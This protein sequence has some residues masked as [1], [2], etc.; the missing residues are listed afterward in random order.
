MTLGEIK[1]E[2]LKIMF[3]AYSNDFSVGELEHIAR[4]DNYASYLAD[5]V[6]S[7][8]RCFANIENKGV[9]KS[10]CILLEN[11][12][13][14]EYTVSYDLDSI[15]DFYRLERVIAEKDG[16]YFPS[17]EYVIE[18]NK[19]VL[20]EKGC[21]YK[22]VYKPRIKRITPETSDGENIGVD[23]SIAVLIPYYIKGDVYRDDEPAEAAEARNWYEAAISE[24]SQHDTGKQ[25]FVHSVYSVEGV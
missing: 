24:I 22:L 18:G 10:K 21:T 7:I 4:D 14:S 5:M 8:N 16:L 23:D 2:A 3:A 25:A 15:D 9:L 20:F 13:E 6:G 1:V 11:G 19:L 12:T 17:V